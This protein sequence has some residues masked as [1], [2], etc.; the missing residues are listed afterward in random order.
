VATPGV[1]WKVPGW[2]VDPT[3]PLAL[4]WRYLPRLAPWL[5]RFLRAANRA[6]MERSVIACASL[7]SRA[8]EG[9]NA[10]V[11][12]SGV[13]HL[14]VPHDAIT[15]YERDEAFRAD[16]WSWELRRRAGVALCVL[17]A[18][19]IRE[20]EPDLSPSF[21]HAVLAP[22]YHF[23]RD[24]LALARGLAAL[25][26][27]GGG[28][29][30]R[31]RAVSLAASDG[32]AGVSLEGG[33]VISARNAVVALGAWSHLLARTLGDRFPLETERG[34]HTMLPA[35]GVRL[36]RQILLAE[37]SFVM[38]PMDA[39]LRLAGTVELASLDAPPDWRR[40]DILVQKA[41][42]VLPGLKAENP[43]RWMGHRPALP[44]CLPV[45]DRS[46]CARNVFYAFGHGH[47][48]L[49]LSGITGRL[50]ADLVCGRTPPVDLAPFRATRFGT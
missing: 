16:A 26:V 25:F 19:E 4:R 46:P 24:P 15:I 20:L 40:A 44:D 36:S 35:S 39:G 31:G 45:I 29:L 33:E 49:T 47:L 13:E 11:R 34:Y 14:I 10:L 27:S 22:D 2:L 21:R 23:V 8:H 41:R 28:L 37:H 38:T 43:S 3:G 1:I 18:G 50:M 42:H 48:G 9:L 6:T 17:S 32:C 12:N 30:R 5:F 7:A